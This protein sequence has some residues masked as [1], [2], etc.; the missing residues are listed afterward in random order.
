M[1]LESLLTADGA[2]YRSLMRIKRRATWDRITFLQL[3]VKKNVCKN[4][5]NMLLAYN[6]I[7]GEVWMAQVK[8]NFLRLESVSV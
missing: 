3:F 4:S 2:R 8:S 1:G 5:S 7:T 6:R